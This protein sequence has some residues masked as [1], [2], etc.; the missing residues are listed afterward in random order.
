MADF[1]AN[2]TD[3]PFD[4]DGAATL[5]SEFRGAA[6]LL[7][8]KAG[9]YPGLRDGALVRWEGRFAGEFVDRVKVCVEDAGKVATALRTAAEGLEFLASEARYEQSRREAARRWEEQQDRGFFGSIGD[10]VHD[11]F[12]GEDDY[13]PPPPPRDPPVFRPSSAVPADRGGSQPRGPR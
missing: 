1:H 5:A 7:D 11:F 8:E 2:E 13:P 10:N 4:F 6:R 9:D 3:V 12:A